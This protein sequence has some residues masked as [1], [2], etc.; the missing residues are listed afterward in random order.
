MAFQ[1]AANAAE[2]DKVILEL[3]KRGWSYRK[4]GQHV[5][6]SANGVMHALRRIQQGRQGRALR[7]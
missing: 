3:R 7:E 5:G 1:L 6:M 4:I 2:R